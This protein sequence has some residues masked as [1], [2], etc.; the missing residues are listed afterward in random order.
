MYEWGISV[1][2]AVQSLQNP[3]L[4]VIMRI[5]TFLGDPLS[6][7]ILLPIIFWCIDEK[8]GFVL[9]FVSLFSAGINTAIKNTVRVPRP[10]IM[11]P[12]VGLDTVEGFSTP[13]G[14][15]QG[16][17]TFWSL[18]AA[19]A[20]KKRSPHWLRILAAFLLPFL[21]GFSRI[22]LGV[23]Y[24]TDVLLGWIIGA[25]IVALTYYTLPL[26][27][28]YIVSFPKSLLLLLTALITFIFNV[29]SPKDTHMAA[30]FFGF[31]AGF[32][33]LTKTE[34]AAF[35]AKSGTFWQKAARLGIGYLCAGILYVAV[36]FISPVQGKDYYE[37]F[38]FL[39]YSV[40]AFFASY[41]APK[42]FIALK[43]AS[44]HVQS[45]I[46]IEEVRE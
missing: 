5:I 17:V 41:A 13:S 27:I 21:I 32:I 7:I 8:K 31:T 33:F 42:L 3:F 34:N 35:S 25:L 1:I 26:I 43:L 46:H 39:R 44:V 11:E 20:D 45:D 18:S 19:L 29:F 15:A 4:T 23:H 10:Y 16:S 40:V 6:Y 30:A 9:G 24:P 37:L 2:Q 38:H 14:H 36:K 22:Y 28:R 12:S